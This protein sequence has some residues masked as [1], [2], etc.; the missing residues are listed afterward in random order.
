[1]GAPLAFLICSV[2]ILGLFYLDRDKSVRV[3]AALWLPV[4]WLWIAG[5]RSVSSWLGVT[6]PSS[7]NVLAS[8]L[9]GSPLDA[10]IYEFLIVVGLIVLFQRRRKTNA[11][12]KASFPILIYFFY[13]LMS[14]AWSPFHGPSFKRWIKAV[15]DLVMVLIVVTDAHPVAALRR[16]YSRVGFILLPFSVVLIRY[17]DMGRGY[18]PEGNPMNTGVTTNKNSLG[19]ILFVVS[20]GVLWN[21][22]ALWLDKKSPNRTRRL[23]AQATLLTVGIALLQ[24]AHSATSVFCF[25][26]GGGLVLASGLQAIRKRPSRVHALCLGILIL[27]V[28][29]VTFGGG[30]TVTST[31]GRSSDFSGRIEIWKAAIAAAD[32]PVLGTGFESFW[33]TNANKVARILSNYW[34]ISNLNSAHNGYLQIYLD[35]GWVGVGLLSTILIGGYVRAVKAFER[36]R[37]LGCLMLAYIV[38]CAFYSITEAGFRILTP[39]WIFFLLAVAGATSVTVGLVGAKKRKMIPVSPTPTDAGTTA[40]AEPIPAKQFAYTVGG[41]QNH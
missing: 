29:T 36:N 18:D 41:N 14:T 13:C 16:L 34:N 35:L 19:L 12:L 6:G 7:G 2:G 24:M 39:S 21:V 30:S 17:T 8:T 20:L 33:N 37:E 4:I 27:G 11:L 9:D 32:S 10:A 1:M 26:L 22:R 3:S 28:L 25:V 31:M 15:G 40:I 38:T 23:V 5:S